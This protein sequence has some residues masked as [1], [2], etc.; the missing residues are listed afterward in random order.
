MKKNWTEINETNGN[1]KRIGIYGTHLEVGNTEYPNYCIGELASILP[2][3]LHYY[4]LVTSEIEFPTRIDYY[5]KLW[6]G[7]ADELP[8]EDSILSKEYVD[9]SG[10]TTFY[11]VIE[12]RANIPNHIF[13]TISSDSSK[14]LFGDDRSLKELDIPSIFKQYQANPAFIK[15]QFPIQFQYMD[16]GFE[17]G[18]HILISDMYKMRTVNFRKIGELG[19][20]GFLMTSR[21]DIVLANMYLEEDYCVIESGTKELIKNLNFIPEVWQCIQSDDGMILLW[22]RSFFIE[23]EEKNII[24]IRN[25]IA[26]YEFWGVGIAGIASIDDEFW[27]LFDEEGTT[28]KGLGSKGLAIVEKNGALRF[29]LHQTACEL[30]FDGTAIAYDVDNEIVWLFQYSWEM[31]G[32]CIALDKYGGI[33]EVI[34]CG[35]SPHSATVMDGIVWGLDEKNMVRHDLI[36][37]TV[38]RFVIADECGKGIDVRHSYAFGGKM[39]VTGKDDVVYLFEVENFLL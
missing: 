8:L 18:M 6:K 38:N 1:Y 21:N 10:F 17:A 13:E 5:K 9:Q 36:Q 24:K 29:P 2:A 16:A 15:G 14:L 28:E 32:Q 39:L 33:Q 11:G 23:D 7:Y 19:K 35:Y 12:F 25:S 37:K 20:N 3:N 34:N 27:L 31:R 4:A 26:E 30:I 22:T